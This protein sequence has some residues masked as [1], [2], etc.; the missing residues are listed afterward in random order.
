MN[1]SVIEVKGGGL[2]GAIE[3]GFQF[4]EVKALFDFEDGVV[5]TSIKNGEVIEGGSMIRAQNVL[6]HGTQYLIVNSFPS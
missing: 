3:R 5:G 1:A 2:D 4:S 6:G